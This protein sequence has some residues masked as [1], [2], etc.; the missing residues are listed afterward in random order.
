MVIGELAGNACHSGNILH[1]DSR[2]LLYTLKN[3]IKDAG[4]LD[5]VTRYIDPLGIEVLVSIMVPGFDQS[6]PL[7][8]AEMIGQGA[9][10]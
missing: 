4:V 7:Q 2:A 9:V 6:L 10:V 3:G 5:T 1:C 8:D